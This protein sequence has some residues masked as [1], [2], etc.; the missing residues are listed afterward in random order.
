MAL[1]SGSKPLAEEDVYEALG[2]SSGGDTTGS[3]ALA[4]SLPKILAGRA[5]THLEGSLL[6]SRWRRQNTLIP[7]S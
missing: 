4:T 1:G 6:G 5:Q 7:F 2:D 3:P